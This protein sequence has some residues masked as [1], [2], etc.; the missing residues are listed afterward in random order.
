MNRIAR[1]TARTDVLDIAYEESGTSDGPAAILLHGFPDDVRSWD[2][3]SPALAEAGCRVIVPYLRGFGPT[4]FLDPR[5]PRVG[6]QAALGLDV[7][8]LMDALG[9][10]RAV[11]A[12][13]DWGCRAACVASII[14]PDRVRGLLAIGGYDVHDHGS[15]HEPAPPS[16]ERERWYHWYFQIERGRRALLEDRREICRY[17]WQ[18]WSPTWAFDEASFRRTA[19]S[20]DNPDFVDVVIQEY[21]HAHGTDP[22]DL[23]YEAIEARLASAPPIEVPSLIL[24]GADD[25]VHPVACSIPRMGRFPSGTQRRVVPEAGHFLPREDPTAVMTAFHDLLRSTRGPGSSEAT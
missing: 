4:R 19:D 5:T 17:M 6:Q 15:R 10:Q 18:T 8:A 22:G 23:G 16:V 9:I 2:G 11:L 20:F 7:I 21:R 25:A 12:G 24:H 14:R 13:F 1:K 3:V